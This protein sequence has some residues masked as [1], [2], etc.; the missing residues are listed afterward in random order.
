MPTLADKRGVE[1][2]VLEL[3]RYRR[4]RGFAAAEFCKNEL[5][6]IQTGLGD[7]AETFVM[8]IINDSPPDDPEYVKAVERLNRISPS[9][10][11]NV[12]KYLSE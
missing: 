9:I 8:G 11:E 6:K 5:E 10:T 2:Y 12:L 4:N 7:R 1:Q 3:A